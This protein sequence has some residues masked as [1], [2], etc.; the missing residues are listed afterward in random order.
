MWETLAFVNLVMGTFFFWLVLMRKVFAFDPVDY[1]RRAY[2]Q[3]A[4]PESPSSARI[5]G[6]LVILTFLGLSVYLTIR[7][8]AFPDLDRWWV[9]FTLVAGLYGLN[10]LPAIRS[11][12]NGGKN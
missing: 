7:G 1:L 9:P 10:Q 6:A 5:N 12:A 3:D 2:S 11:A 8:G 4:G